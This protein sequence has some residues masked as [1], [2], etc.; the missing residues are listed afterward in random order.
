MTK[1]RTSKERI[2]NFIAALVSGKKVLDVGCVDHYAKRE[3]QP[4]WLHRHLRDSASSI[5]GL[6]IL[7]DEVR[8]LAGKGYRVVC[9]DALTVDL[10]DRFDV[11]VAGELI[12]H[13]DN[14]GGLIANL[15]RH[16]KPDG[17]LV[18]TTPNPF[19]VLHFI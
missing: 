9:A 17:M 3:T 12:E 15:A 13:V 2:E 18:I 19:Y 10:A 11:I 8:Q 7:E 14:P 5:V 1:T 4:T 6:D 16:L